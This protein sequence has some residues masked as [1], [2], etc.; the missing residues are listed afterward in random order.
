MSTR[1]HPTA[2]ISQGAELGLDVE[3]AVGLKARIRV[4]GLGKKLLFEHGIDI[5]RGADR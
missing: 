5:Q 2:V 4:L 1:I 3:A